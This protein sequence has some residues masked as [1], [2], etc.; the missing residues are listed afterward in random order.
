MSK[1]DKGEKSPAFMLAE[2]INMR[3]DFK[4]N[5]ETRTSCEISKD[6]V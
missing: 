5:K 1:K 6:V 4:E 2:G 3:F